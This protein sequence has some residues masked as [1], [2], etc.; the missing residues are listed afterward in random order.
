MA[1]SC[2][3]LRRLQALPWLSSSGEVAAFSSAMGLRPEWICAFLAGSFATL[4]SHKSEPRA[5][6]RSGSQGFLESQFGLFVTN[7][8]NERIEK[9]SLNIL[10]QLK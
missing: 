4:N 2:A 3:L 10:Q 7:Y 6:Q 8:N 5:A 1:Q 9:G